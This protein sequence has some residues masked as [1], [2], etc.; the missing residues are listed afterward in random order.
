MKSGIIAV[1]G[2]P[3]VGK[4]TLLN[5]LVGEKLTIVS[6]KPQ[7]TWQRLHGIL[8][9]DDAQF[10]FIDTPGLETEKKSSFISILKKIT[11]SAMNDADII[12]HLVE[13]FLT[14]KEQPVIKEL[15]A[16]KQKPKLLFINKID[17]KKDKRLILPVIEYYAKT[18]I[19]NEI[20][21]ASALSGEGVDILL[22]QLERYLPNEGMLYSDDIIT[23]KYEKE[24]VS[25]IVR[26]KVFYYTRDE[27]PY[28]VACVVDKFDET[29]RDKIIRI[30][31]TIYVEKYSQKGILI[32]SK[33]SMLKKIGTAARK[34]MED[35]LG[36]KVYLELHVK[37]KEDWKK[38]KRFLKEIGLV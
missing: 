30:Y 11:V 26:E 32:G 20:I 27:I 6:P 14:D 17:L 13:P 3:N 1:I 28:A 23:D 25:E 8:T 15:E 34:D 12:L 19:Y 31:I 29:Q 37:V 18:G 4:S 9:T 36:T 21:P 22:K 7:T 10:V 2:R 5:R 38:D 16:L 33:G 24:L 35:L